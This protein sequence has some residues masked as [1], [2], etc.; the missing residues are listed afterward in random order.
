MTGQD[1]ARCVEAI[2]T[3]AAPAAIGPYSQAIRAG[4]FVFVSGQLPI[5]PASGEIEATTAADQALASIG[6]IEAILASVG[7]GLP[8]V[9]KTTVL[10]TDIADF[11]AV[12]EAYAS[13]FTGPVPPARAA[14]Q[15]VALPKGALVEIEAI[16]CGA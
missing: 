10:L 6:N 9:V 11:A 5:N 14:Y 3:T 13:R 7:L 8:D 4:Q 16:A 1:S 12:N 2:S 15:V